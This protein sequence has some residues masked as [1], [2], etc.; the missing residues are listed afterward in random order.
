[1]TDPIPLARRAEER[2]AGAR[3][4]EARVRA[5]LGVAP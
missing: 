1:M 3:R 4:E 5:A 2:L